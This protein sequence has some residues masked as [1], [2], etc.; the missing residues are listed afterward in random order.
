MMLSSAGQ[1][2]LDAFTKAVVDEENK[3][4]SVTISN[5]TP[6]FITSYTAGM[7]SVGK[8]EGQ[9]KDKEKGIVLKSVYY[10]AKESGSN[11]SKFS[12]G[13]ERSQS[14]TQTT[15]ELTI[16]QETNAFHQSDMNNVSTGHSDSLAGCRSPFFQRLLGVFLV[17]DRSANWKLQEPGFKQ[18]RTSY[19]RSPAWP[20]AGFKN[21]L[22]NPIVE[23]RVGG[24]GAEK[25]DRLLCDSTYVP[26]NSPSQLNRNHESQQRFP[27]SRR[28][29][30]YEFIH[31][32]THY[33][34]P[35][36]T[37]SE[38]SA[39]CSKSMEQYAP[40]VPE[41]HSQSTF[42]SS[43]PHPYKKQQECG[44]F[45]K[46]RE[47][48]DDEPIG[49][50]PLI[51]LEKHTPSKKGEQR[52]YSRRNG[53]GANED[54]QSAQVSPD[55]RNVVFDSRSISVFPRPA[56]S[57]VHK[58]YPI[59][60]KAERKK[61][62]QNPSGRP[63]RCQLGNA[64]SH[65]CFSELA[66]PVEGNG[67][68]ISK[69][70]SNQQSKLSDSN[71]STL[72]SDLD[73]QHQNQNLK[74]KQFEDNTCATAISLLPKDVMES[75]SEF[76]K[77]LSSKNSYISPISKAKNYKCYLIGCSKE[78]P[79]LEQLFLHLRHHSNQEP[80]RFYLCPWKGCGKKF[81][82]R[83]ERKRHYR[84]HTGEKPYKCEHCGR[85]FARLD[86]QKSHLKNIHHVMDVD[87]KMGRADS[88]SPGR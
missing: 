35:S 38:K 45:K 77:R 9:Q 83:D 37:T 39:V 25:M 69:T 40:K 17:R 31:P 72:D 58:N 54:G 42:A 79:K 10:S 30:S 61:K 36:L 23:E 57:K 71:I 82:R 29:S 76:A 53:N 84:C 81:K 48:F 80:P 70:V 46:K 86:H 19:T 41:S 20:S 22:E 33:L 24:F 5:D 1:A 44:N 47:S 52:V 21:Q 26:Q 85:R 73:T 59:R 14:T 27:M 64:F 34:L 67:F 12:R 63:R 7:R 11:L 13:A 87:C 88:S 78:F 51:T 66:A 6:N 55:R 65:G 28:R 75:T 16:T 4:L 18:A 60:E 50:N 15:G 74:E 32:S 2:E 68:Y 43:S 3:S 49:L 8:K 56:P 62:N